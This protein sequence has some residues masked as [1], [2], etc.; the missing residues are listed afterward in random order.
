MLERFLHHQ[1]LHPSVDDA[2]DVEDEDKDDVVDAVDVSSSLTSS[3]SP[4]IILS[5]SFYIECSRLFSNE[6]LSGWLH[7]NSRTD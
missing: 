6:F 1:L 2:D 4:L 5:T 3:Q 7:I